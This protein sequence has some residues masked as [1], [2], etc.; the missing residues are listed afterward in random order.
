MFCLVLACFGLLALAPLDSAPEPL[1]APPEDSQ[2]QLLWTSEDPR[3]CG[4]SAEV[5][6]TD[7]NR[8]IPGHAALVFSSA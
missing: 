7:E 3:Y 2:W 5:P 4:R 6:D 1:L 8:R